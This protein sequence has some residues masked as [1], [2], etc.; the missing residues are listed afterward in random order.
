MLSTSAQRDIP[1]WQL[2]G[3]FSLLCPVQEE[4]LTS[5][6]QGKR[7][8]NVDDSGCIG[9]TPLP[10]AEYSR[11]N[12]KVAASTDTCDRASSTYDLYTCLQYL[13][14]YI[15]PARICQLCTSGVWLLVGVHVWPV[16]VTPVDPVKIK[17]SSAL[18]A[19]EGW[20]WD[21]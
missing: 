20:G 1:W 4:E 3:H 2:H 5:S 7:L 11:L 10:A 8:Y 16:F 14:Q 6:L 19:M 21:P 17:V 9:N 13:R 18:N 12:L 15:C